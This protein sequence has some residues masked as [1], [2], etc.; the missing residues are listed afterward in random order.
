MRTWILFPAFT[1]KRAGAA[2]GLTTGVVLLNT[3]FLVVWAEVFP[4]SNIADRTK[5]SKTLDLI[6]FMIFILPIG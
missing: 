5:P 6:V 1:R 2:T 3:G 4:A